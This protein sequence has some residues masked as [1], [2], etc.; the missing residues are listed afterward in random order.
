[1]DRSILSKQIKIPRICRLQLDTL[2]ITHYI[3][4]LFLQSNSSLKGLLGLM[5][6]ILVHLWGLCRQRW[7][8]YTCTVIYTNVSEHIACKN[9]KRILTRKSVMLTKKWSIW[10]PAADM[11]R[12]MILV[13]FL[14]KGVFHK[15]WSS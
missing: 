14:V 11:C 10:E 3:S 6:D 8:I 12:G 15:R 7:R 5:M 2:K 4:K 1:M 13:L 9:K